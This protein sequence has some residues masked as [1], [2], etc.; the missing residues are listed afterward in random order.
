V[1]G[2]PREE[3]IRRMYAEYSLLRRLAE[4]L[5]RNI[6]LLNSLIADTRAAREV[7]AEVEKIR[8]GQELVV[9]IGGTLYLRTRYKQERRVLTNVGSGVV[10]EKDYKEA[11]EYLER[12]ERMLEQQ[13]RKA[14]ADYRGVLARMQQIEQALAGLA[15]QE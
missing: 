11:L 1:S 5:S 15:G 2:A 12:R 4:S 8:D 13:L 10:V 14:S 3:E 6:A 9:P 7:V